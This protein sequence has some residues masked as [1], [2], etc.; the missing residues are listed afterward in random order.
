MLN[1]ICV[2]IFMLVRWVCPDYGVS[3]VSSIYSF[4]ALHIFVNFISM[5]IITCKYFFLENCICV[6]SVMTPSKSTEISSSH[7]VLR[8]F[9]L[10]LIDAHRCMVKDYIF[11]FCN[12]YFS[13]FCQ[14]V[15]SFFIIF[16]L[17]MLIFIF[18]Q[19]E[20]T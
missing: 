12:C 7:K 8:C 13:P 20:N 2:R 1:I 16:Y 9:Q 19:Y 10:W 14:I 18:L 3:I 11:D 6:F 4:K 5:K 15:L 17:T